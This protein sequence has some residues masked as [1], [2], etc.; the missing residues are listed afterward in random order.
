MSNN[1]FNIQAILS[2]LEAIGALSP[3]DRDWRQLDYQEPQWLDAEVIQISGLEQDFPQADWHLDGS[4]NRKV[5][6][7]LDPHGTNS[8]I[9]EHDS[10][11]PNWQEL[12]IEVLAWYRAFHFDGKPRLKW[13]RPWGIYIRARGVEVIARALESSGVP[14]AQCPQL[15]FDFLKAHELGHFGVEMLATSIELGSASSFFL[16]GRMAGPAWIETEEGVCN[17][18][19]R[20]V[21]P[22]DYK[23]ALDSWLST[24]PS[25]YRDWKQHSP[26]RRNADLA[27]VIST[28]HYDSD[29]RSVAS[30]HA[31][32]SSILTWL[33]N[34]DI[35]KIRRDVPVYMVMDGRGTRGFPINAF[36]GSLAIGTETDSFMKD[37]KK[38]GRPGIL[39]QWNATKE[40]L[41]KGML[42]AVHLEKIKNTSSVYSARVGGDGVRVALKHEP[43]AGLF[44]P[45]AIDNHDD[46]YARMSRA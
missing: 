34:P 11:L 40:K 9:Q 39:K 13:S 35:S 31:P 37:L 7:G 21:L 22:K 23:A 14:S 19:A 3:S 12:G 32:H 33:P 38:L 16:D 10:D 15:A 28:I 26:A 25:G 1:G 46:L 27:S 45:V 36:F 4:S 42:P 5:F 24:C 18:L 43:N 2:G 30:R 6:V 44:I 29:N 20:Q 17:N 41:A 8:Q